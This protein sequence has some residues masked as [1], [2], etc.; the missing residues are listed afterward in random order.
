MIIPRQQNILL[1]NFLDSGRDG[2]VESNDLEVLLLVDTSRHDARVRW[3]TCRVTLGIW[4]WPFRTEVT[5]FGPWLLLLLP[6]AQPPLGKHEFFSII[7]LTTSF[8][9]LLRRAL[10]LFPLFIPSGTVSSCKTYR[11]LKGSDGCYRF[12]QIR[13]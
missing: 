3:R 4:V 6:C 7:R 8:M 9:R 12:V 13:I 11:S 5:P 1:F 10:L 2:G